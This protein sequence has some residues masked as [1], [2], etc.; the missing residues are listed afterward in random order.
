ML[1]VVWLVNFLSFLSLCFRHC[2]YSVHCSLYI[3]CFTIFSLSLIRCQRTSFGRNEHTR[4]YTHSHTHMYIRPDSKR[5]DESKKK[6]LQH[7]EKYIKNTADSI[8]PSQIDFHNCRK[9]IRM[10][11]LSLYFHHIIA[12]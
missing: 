5:F 6:M 9:E 7:N 1:C 8:N 4:T 3:V 10:L 12:I 2:V 11:I